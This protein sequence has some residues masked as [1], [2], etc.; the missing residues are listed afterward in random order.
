MNLNGFAVLRE[1]ILFPDH[2]ELNFC[3]QENP[4]D[5]CNEAER[6]ISIAVVWDGI[7]QKTTKI[8]E[9][10]KIRNDY[11]NWRESD[12]GIDLGDDASPEESL[13]F[14]NQYVVNWKNAVEQIYTEYPD[15][16]PSNN[17]QKQNMYAKNTNSSETHYKYRNGIK[18]FTDKPPA[19][20]NPEINDY[21]DNNIKLL[22]KRFVIYEDP[23]TFSNI[24]KKR[25]QISLAVVCT[26]FHVD[27]LRRKNS[28][29]MT[30]QHTHSHCNGQHNKIKLMKFHKYNYNSTWWESPCGMNINNIDAEQYYTNFTQAVKL[31]T[32]ILN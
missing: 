20:F 22:S 5:K 12:W 11:G 27:Y 31:M 15:I 17:P 13:Y 28:G 3:N 29:L 19:M 8:K 10:T 23:S 26:N 16:T 30:S 24:D 25:R 1:I 21:V 7:T 18:I 4:C 6:R 14:W 2:T 9:F 32:A